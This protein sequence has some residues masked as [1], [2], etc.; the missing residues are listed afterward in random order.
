MFAQVVLSALVVATCGHSMGRVGGSET[1]Y[2]SKTMGVNH[3][4]VVYDSQ[5]DA[6]S[7]KSYQGDASMQTVCKLAWSLLISIVSE[8]HKILIN[9]FKFAS[10]F[11]SQRMEPPL[12]G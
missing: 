3:P 4:Y 12:R 1:V 11:Q 2:D 7:G 8:N 6:A 5:R 9:Y 10:R